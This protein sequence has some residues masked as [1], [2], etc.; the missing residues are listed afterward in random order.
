M[1]R[2]PPFDTVDLLSNKRRELDDKG[3]PVDKVDPWI[4]LVGSARV[5][6]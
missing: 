2:R 5:P 6:H 4:N 1:V 3:V